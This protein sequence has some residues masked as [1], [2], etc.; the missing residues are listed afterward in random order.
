MGQT[1]GFLP[2]LKPVS[3]ILGDP[4]K[5]GTLG[6]IF[7]GK[8]G[9][10]LGKWGSR[11][12]SRKSMTGVPQAAFQHF[13]CLLKY[14]REQASTCQHSQ[15]T[16]WRVKPQN[17]EDLPAMSLIDTSVTDATLMAIPSGCDQSAREINTQVELMQPVCC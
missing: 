16:T 13:T 2:R 15:S 3:L 14:K 17:Q 6:P 10:P 5:I 9:N 11:V 12:T 7:R 8:M 4:V 1:S